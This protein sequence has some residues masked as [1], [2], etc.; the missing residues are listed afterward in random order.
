MDFMECLKDWK[1]GLT[2]DDEFQTYWLEQKKE[3]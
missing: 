1:D 3:D 2:T